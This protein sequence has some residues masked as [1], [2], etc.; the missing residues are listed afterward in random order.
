MDG[1]LS[2]ASVER[3]VLR[4]PRLH[5]GPTAK[6]LHW[7]VAV[8][9]AVQLPLGWLMRGLRRGQPPDSALMVHVTIG[10]LILSLIVARFAWRLSHPVTPETNL[11][12]WQR[13]SS[14]WV[15][16]L[17]Y[18]AV[19]VTALT[20]WLLDSARGTAA[21]LVGGVPL[22]RLAAQG[23]TWATA[24]G[25]LHATLVWVLVALI[26][27]HVLAALVHLLVYRD[28]VMHRMLPGG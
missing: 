6:A 20:G 11:P 18:L 23:N 17:L 28:R 22:P 24:V 25:N 8:L 1:S 16:W 7:A 26:G 14:E 9:L 15:H 12:A 21:A 2:I 27:A 3:P 13:V 19:L 10:L 5:Y 4:V